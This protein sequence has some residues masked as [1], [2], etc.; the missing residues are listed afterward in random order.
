ML[1]YRRA[2]IAATCL[3]I[4]KCPA[5]WAKL[6]A[7]AILAAL[8]AI[9]YAQGVTITPL[10]QS[11]PPVGS[12]CAS[13]YTELQGDMVAFNAFLALPNLTWTPIPFAAG[14]ST[15]YAANL[16]WA[17]GNT[18][19]SIG[20]TGYLQSTV[21][22][23]IQAEKALGVQAIVVPVLFP[24]LC[25]PNPADGAQFC[26]NFYGVP[27]T[28]AANNAYQ[29]YLTF[30]TQVAQAIRAAGL[31]L[32][33]DNEILFSNDTAAGWTNMN[34]FYGPLTWTEYIAA[35][36]AMA[37][38]VEKYMQPD[39]LM[40]A[41]EPDTEA[42]QT[43]QSS[44][45][46]ATDAAAMVQAEITAVRTYLASNTVSPVPLLGAGFGSWF[47]L[48]SGQLVDYITSYTALNLDYIDFHMLP[49]NTVAGDDFLQNTITIASM[50]AATGKPVAVTQAWLE[51]E[52]ALEVNNLNIDVVRA[53]GPFSFWA[54]LNDSFLQ[55]AQNLAQYTNMLYLGPQFPV[56]LNAYQT[57]GG[58]VANGGA[59]NCTCTTTSCSDYEI[60][61]IENQVATAADQQ[62]VY[63]PTAVSYYNQLVT[64]PDTTPPSMP[65]NLT[66]SAGFT[67]ANLSWSQSTDNVGVAGY[68]VLRCSPP[69]EGG[70]CTAIYLANADP[71]CNVPPPGA[72]SATNCLVTFGDSTLTS[73]TPYNYQ[74][75][76]FD[77]AGNT[78]APSATFSLQ[79]YQTSSSS[80]TGLT[81][82]AASA[83][84]INLSWSAPPNGVST[85][86]LIYAGTSLSGLQQIATRPNGTTTYE[87]LSLSPAATYYFGIVAEQQGIKAPMSPTAYA[88]TL[89][90]PPPPSNVQATTIDPTKIVLTWQDAPAAGGLPINN[91]EIFDGTTPG[92]M[93]QVG[94]ATAANP[95]TTLTGLSPSTTYYF[96]IVAVDTGTPR[97]YSAPSNAVAFTTLPM[98]AAPANVVATA[99]TATK[100]TVTWTE[101][102]PTGG[103]PISSYA[104]YRGAAPNPTTLIGNASKTP[105][106]EYIDTK[107]VGNTTYYY[108]VKATDSAQD[109]SPESASAEVTTPPAPA[110]PAAP[111]SLAVK[112]NSATELTLTWSEN[113][114]TGGLPIANYTINWGTSPTSLTNSATRTT[115]TFVDTGL[116][117]G[118]TYYFEVK[119]TD[120]SGDVSPESAIVPGTTAVI[121][122]APTNVVATGT[123]STAITV[124][125]TENIPTGGL[126]VTVYTIN[127]GLSP[128]SLTNS[129]KRTTTTF[130]D[131]GLTAGTTY[132]FSITASDS[133]GDVSPASATV[134]GTTQ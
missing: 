17:N 105:P 96:E 108:A 90:L 91:Y 73:G 99:N 82:T 122:A 29:P 129:A 13:I 124:T 67:T 127:W 48:G 104:V 132:Y 2:R 63:T 50:A 101:T 22:P 14:G 40:L 47:Q 38:T 123:S 131:T 98:P 128:T 130:V 45:N 59:A 133:G 36:A 95:T 61:Q 92:D 78:S 60:M 117:A 88:A 76:A 55:M 68:N 53:R 113:I 62:S 134:S 114:P 1:S 52:S 11:A 4:R 69:T 57:Y 79:T 85:T 43:G 77:F 3:S 18:G 75:E 64:T 26:G 89:P 15:L 7:C 74:V 41:N 28:T 32:I 70:A 54:P 19:P 33:V 39:Y 110:M 112:V 44:L 126:P 120:T 8:P 72:P 94:T 46:T 5:A 118:T 103:L 119:A 51:D 37:V 109:V 21:E 31:K 102:I 116:T 106:L 100:V 9:V 27:G 121:P 24:I 6:R 125:W 80:A 16:Q 49:I 12:Y 23:E 56:Y 35:R 115:A 97:D 42:W 58:T 93:K 84:Q 111:S 10:S 34:A 25:D 30:Y 81:A 83:Q 66:G 86:Y 71:A 20:G 87:A 107:A 65:T